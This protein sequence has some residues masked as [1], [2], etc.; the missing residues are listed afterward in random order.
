MWRVHVEF[1]PSLI[2]FQRWSP[3]GDVSMKRPLFSLPRSLF[4]LLVLVLI[5]ACATSPR[6]STDMDPRADLSRYRSYGFHEP[7]AMEQSGYTTYLTEQIRTSIRRQMDARGYTFDPVNPD[8]RVNFQGIVRERTDVYSFPRSDF[9]YFYNYRAHRYVGYPLW[10]DQT[11]V[12]TYA[13]GTLTI[14]LVDAARN[15][16]VWT[17]SA[18]GRVVQR[19]PQERVIAADQAIASIFAR[20]PYTAG[21]VPRPG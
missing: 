3:F 6:V 1:G 12:Q 10:Y 14:D 7:V 11:Q 17:G 5:A 19:T 4:A 16:L 21:L 9:G 18:I 15:H 2:A 13:E 8:I 20:F